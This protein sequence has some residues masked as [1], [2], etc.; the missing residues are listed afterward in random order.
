MDFSFGIVTSGLEDARINE[1]IDSIEKQNIPNYEIIIVGNSKVIRDKTQIIEFDESMVPLWIT[2]KKNIITSVSEFENIVYLHDYVKFEDNWY[3]GFLKFGN[4]FDLCMN[5]ILNYDDTRFRDWFVC[6]WTNPLDWDHLGYEDYVI[7]NIVGPERKCL[8]PYDENRL[9]K[10]MYFSGTYWVAK[11]KI[12]LEFPL[13]ENFCWGQGE[14]VE[15]SYRV[16]EKY[17]FTMNE[18]STVK[19][20]KYKDVIFNYADAEIIENLVHLNN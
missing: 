4:N 17:D 2:R 14:D 5:E 10:N 15:W 18:Y 9:I 7:S 1:I 11:K 12:M 6:M 8:I 13:D 16:R 3:E 19:L 20:M